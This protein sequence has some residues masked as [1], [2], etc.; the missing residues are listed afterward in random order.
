MREAGLVFQ[1]R[2]GPR[3]VWGDP[4]EETMI[5]ESDGT[6]IF[7][8]GL[9]DGPIISNAWGDTNCNWTKLRMPHRPGS[10]CK[11]RPHAGRI[12]VWMAICLRSQAPSVEHEVAVRHPHP[13]T[14]ADADVASTRISSTEVMKERRTESSVRRFRW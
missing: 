7:P 10:N 13:A 12:P 4:I 8:R 2:G 9:G 3:S 5:M 11:L 1:E 14:Q 6:E